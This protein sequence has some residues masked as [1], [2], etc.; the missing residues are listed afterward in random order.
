M[1]DV[2]GEPGTTPMS[3][4]ERPGGVSLASALV[5][6]A[7]PRSTVTGKPEALGERTESGNRVVVGGRHDEDGSGLGPGK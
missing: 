2:G 1:R 6:Q 3:G 7:R 4:Y 5:S